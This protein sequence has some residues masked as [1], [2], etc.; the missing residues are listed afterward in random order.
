MP[1]AI[2][3]QEQQTLTDRKAQI[4]SM[5]E[6]APRKSHGQWT[7][8]QSRPDPISLLQAQD[9]GRLQQLLPIKYGRMLESPFSF[10]RGSAVVMTADLENSPVS[11]LEAIICGDAHLSNFGIFATPERRMVFDIND[12]DEAYYGPWEW[13]LKRLAAS[14]V[15][16]GRGNGF[17]EKKCRRSVSDTTKV[18]AYAM[19]KFS[20]EHVLD[21]W[22]YYVNVDSVLQIM[23]KASKQGG[24][25]AQKLVQ[26]ASKK[27]HQQTLEKLTKIEDGRRQIIS[28][29]PLL[30]PFREMGLERYLDAEDLRHATEQSIKEIWSQYLE[31]LPDE[32]HYLLNQF[33]IRDAALR[34]GGVGSVGTRCMIVL[35]E[36]EAEGDALILQLK[37]AGPSVL[38]AHVGKPNP[39][40]NAQRVVTGQHLMQATSDI[41]LGWHTS[42]LSD[43]EYYWRQLKDMKG[44]ADVS[45]MDYESF[46]SYLGVCAWCLARA[47]AR[48]GDETGIAGYIGTNDDFAQAIS[49]FA[50]AYA[51][52][53]ESDYKA[54]VEAVKSGR[55]TAETGI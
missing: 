30:V 16:A 45:G 6:K 44:S 19:D 55:I 15:V 11:G 47:H 51:D 31:S 22:Y 37:E 34:V 7:P 17:S 2:D 14:A 32:R 36:S 13:D 38:E 10:L 23:E 33:R 41:F 9:K 54:L 29:P 24:K 46:K 42:N 5:R 52:Q 27:T 8:S 43:R 25:S 35:L 4:R 53:T 40:G 48:T 49:Q 28:N 1:T 20:Q 3:N 18:Y 26:K 39:M 12:F 21:V 50:V